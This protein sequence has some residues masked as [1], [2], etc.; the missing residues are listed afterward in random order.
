MSES[1]IKTAKCCYYCGSEVGLVRHHALKGTARRRLAEEDGLWIWICP[2]HHDMIHGKDGHEMDVRLKAAAEIAWL[3]H[4]TDK[5][6][7]DF[8]VRY[9]KHF[10]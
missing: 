10:V 7:I 9:G 4:N 6:E 8:L 5:D 2:F 1:I 3:K